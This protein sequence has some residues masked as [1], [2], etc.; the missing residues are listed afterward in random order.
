MS[1]F[2]WI[3]GAL[4]LD[5]VNSEWISNGARV[6]G[7]SDLATLQTWLRATSD[8]YAEA[9][10]LRE[11]ELHEGDGVLEAAKQLRAALRSACEAAHTGQSVPA[12]VLAQLN[13]ALSLRGVVSHLEATPEGWQEREVLTYD[14]K[15]PLWLLARSAAHS[16]TAGE[17]KRLKPC[18]NPNCILWFL[19]TSKNGTRRWCSMQACGN[20]HKVTAHYERQKQ[21]GE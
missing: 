14:P 13:A 20:R 10:S 21:R 8:H 6:D 12:E 7:W 3:S 11:L 4:W 17:L 5:A 18:S 19:D 16:W 2:F 1:D 9:E 15:A